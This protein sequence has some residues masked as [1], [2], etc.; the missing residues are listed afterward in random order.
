MALK[1]ETVARRF[2]EEV[3]NQ[4]QLDAVDELSHPDAVSHRCNGE[5][6]DVDEFR[7]KVLQNFKGAIPDLRVEIE[8]IV[9]TEEQ[10]VVRW[11]STGT[12]VGEGF[13]LTPTGQPVDFRGMTWLRFRDGK[14]AEGWD[15]WDETGIV[16]RL[17]GATT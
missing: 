17:T 4:N 3:W 2:F 6:C 14:I 11:R 5:T 15:C 12:H 10:A 1:S 16:Q 7:D 8:D 9:A 13:G